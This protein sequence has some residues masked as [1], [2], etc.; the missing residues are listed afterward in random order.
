MSGRGTR[1]VSRRI[2]H[3]LSFSP[4]W[5]AVAADGRTAPATLL[6]PGAARRGPGDTTVRL[7]M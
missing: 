5:H 3:R 7:D 4:A 1:N 6:R 2:D